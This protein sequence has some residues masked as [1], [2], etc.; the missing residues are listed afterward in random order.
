MI[1]SRK[2][3]YTGVVP[4]KKDSLTFWDSDNKSNYMGDQFCSV[5]TKEDTS[6]L[7]DLGPSHTPREP[8]I[9]VS[10]KGVL[11]L[12]KEIKPHK[13]TGP[14][15]IPGRVLK[16]GAEESPIFSRSQSTTGKYHWTGSQS[17]QFSRREIIRP[18]QT[19]GPQ[20]HLIKVSCLHSVISHF[21]RHKILTDC[22]HGFRMCRLCETQLLLTTYDL[23]RGLQD[24][25]QVDAV[26]LDFSKAFDQVLL[27]LKH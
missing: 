19:T 21:E 24:K 27:K 10:T 18:H 13:A 11:K 7:S 25:Q 20:T 12:L 1:K 15:N 5:F 23:A 26:L 2:K 14:D 8:S 3:D 4:L 17:L 22:Q 6:C 16:E 9:K